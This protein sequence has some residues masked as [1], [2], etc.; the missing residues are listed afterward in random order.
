L[1][2]ISD[3]ITS[4]PTPPAAFR[5][6]VGADAAIA[7]MS[8]SG[9][10]TGSGASLGVP[11][12]RWP[13]AIRRRLKNGVATAYIAIATAKNT[14]IATQIQSRAKWFTAMPAQIPPMSRSS[15]PT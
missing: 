14:T 15:I 12:T 10:A 6:I 3:R 1:T 13:S 7:R 11:M 5:A 9:A 2:T 4:R 8:A